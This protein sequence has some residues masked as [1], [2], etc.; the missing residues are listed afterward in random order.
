MPAKAVAREAPKA[1]LARRI[2]IIFDNSPG[3]RPVAVRHA[4]MH[5]A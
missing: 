4:A 2:R 5:A 3:Q 1:R